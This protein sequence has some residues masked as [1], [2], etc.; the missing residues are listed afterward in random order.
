MKKI[1]I[2]VVC[3]SALGMLAG[4]ARLPFGKSEK[5]GKEP[6][7]ATMTVG[8][9][10][11][12]EDINEFFYTIENIN[13]DAYYLRY[14]F[15]VEDGKHMFFFEERRRPDDYGPA[16]EEDTVAKSEF[17]L[18]DK[19]W[20]KFYEIISGGEVS[21]R[22]ENPE[23]GDSGPWTYLYW[24]GDEDKYQEFSFKSKIKGRDFEKLCERLVKKGGK[25]EKD[26]S[27]REE[28][29]NLARD[30]FEQ[31]FDENIAKSSGRESFVTEYTGEGIYYTEY[32]KEL[33]GAIDHYI[34]DLDDDG[35]DEMLVIDLSNDDDNE[36]L[37]LSV[38]EYNSDKERVD[39]AD[40]Y[41]YGEKMLEADGGETIVFLYR[42][43]DH[44]VIGLM[45]EEYYYTRA[46]G[47]NIVFSALSY[48]GDELTELAYKDYAGSD[49]ED[50][51]YAEVLMKQGIDITWDDLFE[52]DIMDKV[53]KSCDGELLAEIKLFLDKQEDDDYFPVKLYRHTEAVGYS[54]ESLGGK[55]KSGKG[56][57]KK[58]DKT[59]WKSLD[60][61]DDPASEEGS[62][63][64]IFPESANRLLTEDDLNGM[65]NEELRRGRN[66]I[67]ARH[68]RRF[69]DES[70][71]KYFDSRS[72]YEGTIDADDFNKKV[73]LSDIELK[74]MD[75]IKKHEK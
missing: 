26:E 19:E 31:Y 36:S 10:I 18:S 68:G 45:T 25:K 74:N 72:W 23:T 28:S 17:E 65:S 62:D 14:R 50:N 55:D 47:M 71:Q 20:S 40:T 6:S 9:D 22:D 51:G 64:Y 42:H 2:A 11:T 29:G 30:A 5:D 21:K 75:F 43:S 56:N 12:E 60:S 13:Y 15:Y 70:L 73:R 8:E 37:I 52:D 32:P 49:M 4:C 41:E 57:G 69:S 39:I 53:L 16:T 67:A 58:T 3:L 27:E 33:F 24:S 34:G 7:N 63:E 46:D 66:E 54:D 38:F 1:A 35:Q 61:A 48:A 59:M 44:P